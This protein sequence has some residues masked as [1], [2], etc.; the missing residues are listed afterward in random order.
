[1]TYRNIILPF[2]PEQFNTTEDESVRVASASES[3]SE[4]NSDNDDD[5]FVNTNRVCNNYESSAEESE[6]SENNDE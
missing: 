1:M 4:N 5:L 6:S 2:R 3:D